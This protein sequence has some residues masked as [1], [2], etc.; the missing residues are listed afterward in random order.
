MSDDLEELNTLL[1]NSQVAKHKKVISR[2][3]G[4][5]DDTPVDAIGSQDTKPNSKSCMWAIDGKNY[6]GCSESTDQIP[7]GQ[8]EPAVSG[9]GVPFLI[10]LDMAFDSLLDLPDTASEEVIKAIDLFWEREDHFRK[11]GFLWKRGVLLWGPPGGGKTSTL[12]L[13]ARNVHERGGISLFAT[14]PHS[15]S[16]C[17]KLIREIE[18]KRP[19]VVMLEDVDA[20]VDEY[21]ES[22]WLAI[23]DGE[24][25][26]DNVVFV[27]TTNYP[28]RLD[29]RFINRPSRFD[30]LMKIGMPSDDARRV[31]LTAKNERLLDCEE[32]LGKWIKETKG[33][34]IAHMKELITSV[35]CFGIDFDT[36]VRRLRTMIN[37]PIKSDDMG[38]SIGFTRDE[39]T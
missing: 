2:D 11:H 24:M 6:F 37:T 13:L 34:S 4:M 29:K 23:L 8:Y 18:P 38:C 21:G 27:A 33:F 20:L 16:A 1:N 7:C 17:L 35:E 10:K 3:I 15:T 9:Q 19:I 26:I 39:W 31:Y 14:S 25:Q 22:R 12:Q 28:E 30:L 32:E 36:V 5:R